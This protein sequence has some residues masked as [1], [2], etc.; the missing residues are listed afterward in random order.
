MKLLAYIRV[1]SRALLKRGRLNRELD[2]EILSHIQMHAD[3]LERAGVSRADA[4]RQ[5]RLAFGSRERFKEECRDVAG[6]NFIESIAQDVR[7]GSRRLYKNPGFTT[8]A[9]FTLGLGVAASV[10]IFAF[11]DAA[12]IRPLPYKKPAELVNLFESNQTGPQFHLSYLDYLDWKKLSRSFNSVAVYRQ[13]DDLLTTERGTERANGARVSD[14]FFRTLG[15][16]PVLGRDFHDG[17]E[18]TSES[19]SVL[20]SYAGWRKRYDGRSDVLGQTVNLNGIPAVI[21]GVLP[22]DFSFSPVGSAE[23]WL[24]IETSDSCAKNR[25]CHSLVGVARLKD[26]I[27]IAS[28]F[29]EMQAIARQLQTQYPDT[30]RNR[31]ATVISLVD[32]VVGDLRPV[33]LVLL[34]GAALLLL[35]AGVNVAGLLIVRLENR[36]REISVQKALGATPARLVRQFA[37]EGLLLAIPSNLLGLTL[38]YMAIKTSSNLIP[39]DRIA[40][41]PYLD[42]I[43][44]NIDVLLFA[45]AVLLL[46]AI[47]FCLLAVL[48]VS[49]LDAGEGLSETGRN[50]AGSTWARLGGKLVLVELVTAMILLVGAGLLAKSSYLL[51][52]VDTGFEPSNLASIQVWGSGAS[53]A[54]PAKDIELERTVLGKLESLPGVKSAG[55]S[56]YLPVG[57]GD[58]MGAIGIVG[59][60]NIGVNNEVNDR[61]VSSAYFSTIDA[62]LERGR[63]FAETD[64]ASRTPVAIINE[65]FASRFF[66][67]VDPLGQRIMFDPQRPFEIV[68]IVSDIK[69]GPLDMAARPAVYLPFN[70]NPSNQFF[71]TVRSGQDPR[72]MLSSMAQS[73]REID[74]SIATFNLVTIPDRIRDSPSAYLHRSAAW[75]VGGFAGVALILGAV[76]LY[77]VIAYSVSQRTREIGIR[78]ALGADQ[79][80]VRKMILREAGG[81]TAAGIAI[82]VVI[83]FASGTLLRGLLFGVKPWDPGILGLVSIV[84]TGAALLACWVPVVRATRIDPAIAMRCE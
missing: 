57:T 34:S 72:A 36:K 13:E 25:G 50:V 59:N 62:R 61:V 53:Y 10:T 19:R 24:S 6:A 14:N 69:E 12:L 43:G 82:G 67:N 31:G 64:D 37:T 40:S 35:I 39:A 8:T 41:M 83:S 23:F 7:F 75:L 48:R 81:L 28:A 76:G 33:L 71:V 44:I 84:L 56:S 17:E 73:V 58:G 70:Q 32:V 30:N 60:P 11:V 80:A 5:A 2:E 47:L 77:G 29:T 79:A 66:P 45:S 38:A 15:V 22:K 65:T 3:D 18:I 63:Y 42:G 49:S 20:L 54:D 1:A 26:G 68:G 51:L 52:N 16:N 27:S 46:I 55:T 4:E 9:A 21:I 78:M 74:S